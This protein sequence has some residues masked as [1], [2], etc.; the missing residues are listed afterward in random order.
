MT[1]A[2]ERNTPHLVLV[3]DGRNYSHPSITDDPTHAAEE[4]AIETD[5]DM[6]IVAI[7]LAQ[8]LAAEDLL[9]ALHVALPFVEDLAEDKGYKPGVVSKALRTIHAAITKADRNLS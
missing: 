2:T 3:T 6:S 1:N 5:G 7:P 9:A 4:A 8:A